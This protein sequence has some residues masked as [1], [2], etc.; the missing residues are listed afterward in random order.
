MIKI[1]ISSSCVAVATV[2]G[3][4]TTL[5]P[6]FEYNKSQKRIAFSNKEHTK[7]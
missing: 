5:V 4:T 3:Q 1:I 6:V 7:S 2:F